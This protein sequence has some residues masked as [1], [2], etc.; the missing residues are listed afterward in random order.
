MEKPRLVILS[1]TGTA[2]KRT[3]PAVRERDIC[4]IV[5]I[6]GRNESKL[7]AL[8]DEF[9]VPRYFT[10]EVELLDRTR[11]DFAFIGSPPMLHFKQIKLCVERR[12]PVLCEK[13]LSL[14]SREAGEIRALVSQYGVQFRV[15]HHLRHQ[16][17]IRRLREIISRGSLGDL[18]RASMQWSFWLNDSSSNASWKLNRRTGG[19][20]P[21]YDSG[22]HVIDLMLHLLPSP[23]S[24]TALACSS[25]FVDTADNLSALALCGDTILELNASHSIRHPLNDLVF[26]FEKATLRIPHAFSEKSFVRIEIF[27]GEAPVIEELDNINPY[28]KE[29][30]DFIDLLRGKANYG[31]TVDEALRG[32]QIMEAIAISSDTG[33]TITLMD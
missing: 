10:D 9:S 26:D 21:F 32:L 20:N 19:P 11:P 7:S 17:G 18:R 27:S 16:P 24:V 31:T 2:R 13:P 22:I 28:A 5:A 6:H 30:E 29:V 14:T 1:A 15:A 25:R 4:D 33:R 23:R 12:V 3:I 8:A